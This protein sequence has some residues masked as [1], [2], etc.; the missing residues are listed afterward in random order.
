MGSAPC[1]EF[2]S[3]PLLSIKWTRDI[4]AP[5]YPMARTKQVIEHLAV[6]GLEDGEDLVDMLKA[7]SIQPH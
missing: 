1:G 4:Q 3:H 2:S 7:V 5:N 6:R